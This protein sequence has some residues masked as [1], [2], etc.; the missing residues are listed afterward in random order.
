MSKDPSSK[1]ESTDNNCASVTTQDGNKNFSILN[2]IRLSEH[3]LS[4]K[5]GSRLEVL[6]CREKRGCPFYKDRI[7]KEG[8]V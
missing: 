4:C 5:D 7:I 3:C 2:G 1:V 6:T 8:G